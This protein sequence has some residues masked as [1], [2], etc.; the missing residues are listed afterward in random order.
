MAETDGQEK[1][2]E[3]TSKKLT[4]SRDRGE[5]A[6]S[7]EINSFAIFVVG[8]LI[9]LASKDFLGRQFYDISYSTFSRLDSL[10]INR[11]SVQLYFIKWVIFIFESL[12][13]ILI[14][15][16]VVS[17]IASVA[18]VGFKFSW[19]AITPKLSKFNIFANLK[20]IL[21]SS[22]S[23]IEILKA[24]IKIALVTIMSYSVVA[25]LVAD[26]MELPVLSI[27]EI[28]KYMYDACYT[29]VWRVCL[30]YAFFA[31][32]DYAYQRYKHKENLMMTKQEIKE[33]YR[34]SEGDPMIKSRIRRLQQQMTKRRMMQDVPKADVVIT[35]P[36]H[37]AIALKYDMFKDNAPKV[38]AKGVDAVAMRIKAIA[39]ENNIPLHENRELARALF[40]QSQIGE[41][42][43]AALFKSVAQILAYIFSLRKTKRKKSIV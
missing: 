26:S 19:K 10:T 32:A 7:T 3:P 8:L 36:T 37:Y 16:C 20:N 34:Q 22:R 2:E 27:D 18:Q 35:N 33:E 43:P 21:F 40:K 14:G 29:L 38:L 15:I 13:P 42:I 24:V 23:F 41:D 17:V 30:V 11:D 9:L 39:I 1:T 5:V 4:D 31:A 6:K 12:A 28:A 25:K